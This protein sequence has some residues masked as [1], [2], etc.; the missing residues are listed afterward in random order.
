MATPREEDYRKDNLVI[1]EDIFNEWNN[2][3]SIHFQ[4]PRVT[5]AFGSARIAKL[6]EFTDLVNNSDSEQMVSWRYDNGLKEDCYCTKKGAQAWDEVWA[7][8]K[9]M[10]SRL[11]DL[12][13]GYITAGPN[14]ADFGTCSPAKDQTRTDG[15]RASSEAGRVVLHL[16]PWCIAVKDS[17][18]ANDLTAMETPNNG[19]SGVVVPRRGRDHLDADHGSIRIIEGDAGLRTDGDEG[20]HG[21]HRNMS[22]RPVATWQDMKGVDLSS[23]G[24]TDRNAEEARVMSE[25]ADAKLNL[26]NTNETENSFVKDQNYAHIESLLRTQP[27]EVLVIGV[28]GMGGIGKTT[29]AAAIFEEFSP[30]YEVNC[31]LANV[32]EESSKHGFKYIFNKLLSELLQEDIHIDTPTIIS[33]TIMSRLRHKK[34][35][36]VLD[37][38]NSSDLLDNLLGVGHDYLGVGSRVIVTTR[39]RHVLTCRAVDHILEVK[40]MNYHNSLKLFSLNAFNQI[41]PPENGFRER[42]KRAVAYAKGNPLA[43]KVLGSFLRSKSENEWDSALAKLK[44][45]PDANVHKVLRLSFDELDDAEKNI[46]LDIACFFKGEE[47]DKNLPSLEIIDLRGSKRLIECPNFSATPNLKE[48]WFNFCESLTHVHP[49]IF[50]LEKLEFLAVY[51]CKELKSLCSSHCSPSLHTVVAYNCPNLQEFSVPILHQDSK[52]HLHLRS[53]PLKELPPSILHLK[54]LVNFSFP[55]SKN[56]AKLPAN[57]ANQIMLSDISEHEQDAVATLHSVL[58]SPVFKHVKLLKFDNCHSLTELPDNISL[59][60]SLVKL[61]FHKT[62]VIGLPESIKFLPQLKVLKVCHCEMLQFIPVFPPSVECLKVWDCKS[63]K[64]IL[65]LESETPKQHAGTFIF[66]DCM[67]LDENSCNAILKDAIA[68][69]KCWMETILT[70]ESE[71]SEEQRENEDHNVIN[72]GKICY[73]FPTRGSMLQEFFHDYSAQSSISTE[74]PPS[75]NLCGFIFFLVL[76]GAQSCSTD[77]LVINFECECY[78]ETS[79]GESIH[80]ASSAIVEWDCDM[81]F[82]YQLNVM[83]DHVLL[84]YDEECSKQIMETVKGREANTEKKSHFNAKMTVKLVARLPNKEEAMIKECGIRWIYSNVEAGSSREQRSKRIME[85]ED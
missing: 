55:I 28:W 36:I 64:T 11:E 46:F 57:F 78:L 42:S 40:E 52:I 79:W 21:P 58:R 48:V 29:I 70:S 33:S 41:H 49:S 4:I 44:G 19:Q 53:T 74:V 23:A 17:V 50:S 18:V 51:G 76:S 85:D 1:Q 9:K 35:L 25:G 38:V 66:L 82:G 37:D 22:R 56:L 47:R 10:Y 60:S 68:R 34:A 39:D 71:V 6:K 14:Q 8:N 65:S 24:G 75:S 80:V 84:W 2:D 13:V 30:K 27:R 73:F 31:F 20:F 45:T 15:E 81:T 67:N 63:L 62:N 43:L 72:F 83:Q 59:L 77:E 5:E 32:R 26:D 3:N 7:K 12:T 61:S 69:T 54:H 16:G